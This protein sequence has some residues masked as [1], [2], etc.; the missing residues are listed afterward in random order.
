MLSWVFFVALT[1]SNLFAIY[2]I[3]VEVDKK[4]KEG[5]FGYGKTPEDIKRE[6]DKKKGTRRRDE[7]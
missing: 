2:C 7:S 5:I 6:Q 3:K 1:L 4:H